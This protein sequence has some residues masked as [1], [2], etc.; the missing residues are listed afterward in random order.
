MTL[1]GLPDAVVPYEPGVSGFFNPAVEE[2][3]IVMTSSFPMTMGV[4]MVTVRVI[5]SID[6]ARTSVL[7]AG[8]ML[9]LVVTLILLLEM[10]EGTVVPSGNL[11]IIWPPPAA[12]VP[13]AEVV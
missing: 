4:V 7:V 12:S 6:G 13:L 10:L 2:I 8:V 9:A 5:T 11:K 1:K 3:I